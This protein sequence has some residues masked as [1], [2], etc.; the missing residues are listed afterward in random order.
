MLVYASDSASREDMRQ[1]RAGRPACLTLLISR[2]SL[3]AASARIRAPPLVV[4]LLI[5]GS[6]QLAA[7]LQ[8]G[9]LVNLPLQGKGSLLF[10]ASQLGLVGG[11]HPLCPLICCD[12]HLHPPLL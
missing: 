3:T 9:S 1:Q 5:P 6:H 11:P 2:S 12:C 10:C 4:Y 7:L 8:F